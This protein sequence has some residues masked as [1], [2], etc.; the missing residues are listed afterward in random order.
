MRMLNRAGD[1]IANSPLP[2][3][4]VK[5]TTFEVDFGLSNLPQG[6]YLIEIAAA[7]GVDRAVKLLGIRV[8]G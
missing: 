8:T 5:G 7:T 3:P 2:A 6:D 4:T 1:P